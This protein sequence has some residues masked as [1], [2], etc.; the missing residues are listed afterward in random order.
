M[1]KVDVLV[2]IL[3][4]TPQAFE[5]HASAMESEGEGTCKSEDF[6]ANLSGFG[7]DVTDLG[8]IPMFGASIGDYEEIGLTRFSA[9]KKNADMSSTSIVIPCQAERSKLEE[10]ASRSGIQVW[11]NSPLTLFSHCECAR[12]VAVEAEPH[13]LFD[14]ADS[15]A[16]TDCRP[17][18]PGVRVRDEISVAT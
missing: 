1:A 14:L 10:L 4:L 8:P 17:F 3:E 15:A 7:L 18:R 9:P 2:E 11:P 6:L 5:L 13:H 16:R 12:T